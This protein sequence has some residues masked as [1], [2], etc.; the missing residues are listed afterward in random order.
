M[1]EVLILFC[2]A[3]ASGAAPGSIRDIDWKNYSYSRLE[4][5]GVPGELR[6]MELRAKPSVSLING[7]YVM[8]DNCGDDK[9]FCPSLT[10]DSVHYGALAGVDS[11]VAAVV[12][13][14]HTGGTAHWQFVYLL[15]LESGKPRLLAWLRTGSRADQGLRDLSITAGNLVLIVNDPEKRQGDCCSAGTIT[16]RSGGQEV[17]LQR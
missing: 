14:Y 13:T 9:R 7:R 11:V 12:L 8:P 15:T 1:R 3:V 2:C 5:D 17:L 10:F 16:T 4:T 6:W